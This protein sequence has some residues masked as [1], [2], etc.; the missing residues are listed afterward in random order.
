[1]PWRNF[2]QQHD[3][4][5]ILEQDDGDAETLP[6]PSQGTEGCQPCRQLPELQLPPVPAAVA[7]SGVSEAAAVLLCF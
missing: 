1:M 7:L 5:A 2:G 4:E 6:S 3:L